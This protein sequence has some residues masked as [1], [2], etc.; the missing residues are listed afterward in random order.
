MIVGS[1]ALGG[2]RAPLPALPVERPLAVPR[3]WSLLAAGARFGAVD[4]PFAEIRYGV[5]PRIE[6]DLGVDGLDPE[7]GA[8]FQVLRRDPSNSSVAVDLRWDG[9][10]GAG[11]VAARRL[12][13]LLG[14]VGLSGTSALH[15]GTSGSLLLQAGPLAPWASVGWRGGQVRGALGLVVQLSRGFAVHGAL[16]RKR[17]TASVEIAF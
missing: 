8:R 5:L 2:E 12:G 15:W 1:V 17:S 3:G 14:T 10:L 9:D 6:L 4:R 11:L 13:P 7:L 16:G